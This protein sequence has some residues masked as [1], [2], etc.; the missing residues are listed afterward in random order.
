[1]ESDIRRLLHGIGCES[2]RYREIG[3]DERASQAA[4]RLPFVGPLSEVYWFASRRNEGRDGP[5][6]VAS[7]APKSGCTT[8]AR[9]LSRVFRERGARPE[10]LDGALVDT[11]APNAPS[12]ALASARALLVVLAADLPL[13]GT[14]LL[15]LLMAAGGPCRIVL[16]RFDE[17]V[18]EQRRLVD[19]LRSIT[20]PERSVFVLHH[21]QALAAD[22][23]EPQLPRDAQPAFELGRIADWL[24]T[25]GNGQVGVERLGPYGGAV[26]RRDT[27]TR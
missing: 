23:E 3:A 25:T 9:A 17:R 21:E 22:R 14:A 2:L 4:S 15:A 27:G 6:V 7:P 18:A 20:G 13:N 10:L 11:S 8:V 19:A 26:A 12:K 24:E 5:I 16:N 1:M